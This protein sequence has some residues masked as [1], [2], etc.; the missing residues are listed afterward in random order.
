MK[1]TEPDPEV[2]S[3]THAEQLSQAVTSALLEREAQEKMQAAVGGAQAEEDGPWEDIDEEAE[4]DLGKDGL[5]IITRK[6]S[7]SGKPADEIV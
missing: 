1:R 4:V 6:A 5:E 3:K 2:D 7:L